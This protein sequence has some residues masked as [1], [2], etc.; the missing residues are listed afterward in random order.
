[1]TP[2]GQTEVK[3]DDRAGDWAIVTALMQGKET[4]NNGKKQPGFLCDCGIA[5]GEKQRWR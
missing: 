5:Q 4:G 1:M 3:P 2:K